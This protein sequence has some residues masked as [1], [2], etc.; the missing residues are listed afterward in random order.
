V[1]QQKL[2]YLGFGYKI[3]V[4]FFFFFF[5]CDGAMKK[6]RLNLGDRPPSY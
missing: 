1:F 5:G 2:L 3:S 4:F 6:K